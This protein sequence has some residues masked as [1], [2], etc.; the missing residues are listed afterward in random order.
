MGWARPPRER[1]LGKEEAPRRTLVLPSPP[2]EGESE[3]RGPSQNRVGGGPAEPSAHVLASAAAASCAPAVPGRWPRRGWGCHPR[4]GAL[5]AGPAVPQAPGASP[6]GSWLPGLESE[7]TRP[8]TSPPLPLSRP[9]G[10]AGGWAVRR[11]ACVVPSPW[12]SHFSTL[13]PLFV[14]K[15]RVITHTHTHTHGHPVE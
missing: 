13:G 15:T 2:P 6:G 7:D 11:P 3:G 4:P 8:G 14:R 1:A 9:R 10:T 5:H 12:T